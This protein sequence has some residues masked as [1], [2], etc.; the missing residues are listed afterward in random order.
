[1]TTSKKRHVGGTSRQNPGGT[2]K[3]PSVRPK[4]Q[5]EQLHTGGTTE[6]QRNGSAYLH[7]NGSPG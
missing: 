1:M 2:L 5:T 4:T 6:Q 7:G 3:S